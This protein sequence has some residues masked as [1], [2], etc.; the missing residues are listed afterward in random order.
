MKDMPNLDFLRSIAVL[1]VVVSH[2]MI[3]LSVAQ[4]GVWSVGWLGVFGVLIFFVH[5]SLVLMWSLERRP[6]TLDFYIRRIFRIYPLSITAVLV[7]VVT[8]WPLSPP[9]GLVFEFYHRSAGLRAILFSLLLVQDLHGG[10]TIMGVLWTLPHEVEMYVL[11]PFLFFFVR[12]NFS[13]W[14]LLL[15]WVLAA[16]YLCNAA[17]NMYLFPVAIPH[18]LAGVMAYIGFRKWKP[19]LPMWSLG[20][21][22]AVLL[23]GYTAR[24]GWVSGIFVTLPLGLML[25]LFRQIRTSWIAETS[26]QIAKYSYGIYIVHPFCLVVCFYFLAGKPIWMQ[27]GLFIVLLTV[28]VWLAYHCIEKPMIDLGKKVADRAEK[29][30]EQFEL[31]HFSEIEDVRG[32]YS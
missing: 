5:T 2:V 3:A 4:I 12:K 32:S 23:L 29:R 22:L 17:N 25:P 28:L 15:V 18:F 21:L 9:P 31:K 27:V 10:N 13:L 30:F 8:R 7:A 24:P 16:D 20:I 11:L 6:H 19:V 14:P 26:K 1:S